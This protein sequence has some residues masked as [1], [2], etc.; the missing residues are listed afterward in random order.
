MHWES[1]LNLQLVDALSGLDSRG[2]IIFLQNFL[3]LGFEQGKAC[4][5]FGQYE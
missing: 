3:I 2:E 1:Q 4:T 5:R